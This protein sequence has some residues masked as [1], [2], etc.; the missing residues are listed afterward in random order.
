MVAD[1][2]MSSNGETVTDRGETMTD[3]NEE[4]Q[5]SPI[6]SKSEIRKRSGLFPQT[7]RF[8]ILNLKILRLSRQH[9]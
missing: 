4:I 6:P 5:N 2:R 7:I 9:H 8:V 1:T 3:I